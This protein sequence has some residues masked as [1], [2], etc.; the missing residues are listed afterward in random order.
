MS[1][2]L[3]RDGVLDR[4]QTLGYDRIHTEDAQLARLA[5]DTLLAHDQAQRERIEA[6]EAIV[7]AEHG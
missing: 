3:S 7:E 2:Y 6:L 1:D 5:I 4:L